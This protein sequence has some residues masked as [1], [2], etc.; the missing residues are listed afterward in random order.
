MEIYCLKGASSSPRLFGL[1]LS[2]TDAARNS[3]DRP[4]AGTDWELGWELDARNSG[5]R[6]EAG[7]DWELGW[8]LDVINLNVHFSFG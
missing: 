8:E 4:E 1:V 5:D 7:T 6:P 2:Y 3:G